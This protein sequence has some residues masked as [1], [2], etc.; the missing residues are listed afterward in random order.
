MNRPVLPVRS[1]QAGVSTR[2]TDA[3]VPAVLESKVCQDQGPM[4]I[5]PT[6]APGTDGVV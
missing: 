1:L 4:R 2:F 5:L 6:L 3:D